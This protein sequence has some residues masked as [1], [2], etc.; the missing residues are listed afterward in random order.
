MLLVSWLLQLAQE[1]EPKSAGL[2]KATTI[3][4]I[5]VHIVTLPQLLNLN[6]I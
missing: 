1:Y 4:N 5:K 2:F 3:C 6:Q